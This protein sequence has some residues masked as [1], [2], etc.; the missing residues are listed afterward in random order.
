MVKRWRVA[1]FFCGAGGFSEGFRM[2]GFDVVFALDNWNYARLTHKLN[3]PNCNHPGLDCHHET[4]GDILNI[5]TDKIDEIIDDTE[6]IVG[7]PPCVSFSSS[8]R[9]GKADKSLGIKLIEKYLQIIAIKKHKKG[10][11]LKN[12][13]ME[14]VPNSANHI[15]DKYTFLDL[16]INST[17]L[18]L[19]GIKKSPNDIALFIKKENNIFDAVEYGVPQKRKR[20]V[21]GEFNIPQKVTPNEADWNTLGMVIN[22]LKENGNY[23]TDP[24]HNIKINS[25]ELTDHFYDTIIPQFEWEEAL[26]KKQQARYYGKMS[27]PENQEKPSRTIMATRSILAREAMILPN[28]KPGNYRMPTI[29]EAA[30]IMSFP[31]TYLFQAENEAS[32]YRLVGNAVCPLFS[33]ALATQILKE[34]NISIRNKIIT[35][36][37]KSKLNVDLRHTPPPKKIARNKHPLANFVEIVPDIKN[38]NIR[39]ELDNNL[40]RTGKRKLKWTASIHHATGKDSMKYAKATTHQIKTFFNQINEKEKLNKFIKELKKLVDKKIPSAKK[41]QEQHCLANHDNKFLTPRESLN[42]VKNLIEK[43][44]PEREYS[45]H[46]LQIRDPKTNKKIIRFNRGTIPDDKI[47]IR[48]ILAFYGVAKIAEM[49]NNDE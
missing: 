33:Y 39:I 8:N 38:N 5:P 35:K 6:V 21:C 7:S 23:I 11:V 37:D 34:N 30:S 45:N 29:R 46:F 2:A 9:A 47:S 25:D 28:G 12:W 43:Y 1:D 14:N 20:F 16:G 31:I 15:S 49:T 32:K 13:L 41:F 27:F 18:K 44:F 3:H 40:P 42:L 24:I 22:A 10:S 48:H 17:L 36:Q 19:Y 4:G 26:I